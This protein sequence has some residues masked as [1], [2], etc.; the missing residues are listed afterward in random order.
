MSLPR[1]LV[2][3]AN[4]AIGGSCAARLGADGFSVL[5][6]TRNTA[7]VD[8]EIQVSGDGW[9]NGIDGKLA[10]V[11]WAQGANA[12]GSVLT[13]SDEDLTLMFDANVGFI[14]RTVR[15][16]V[17]ADAL[18]ANCRF[19]I[20]SSI[21]QDVARNEKF[22]YTVSKAAI[23]GLVRSLAIDLAPRGI[24]VNAVLPGILDTPMTRAN[25]SPGQIEDALRATP[26]GRLATVEDVANAVSWLS[27]ASCTAITAQFVTVDGGWTV[28]RRV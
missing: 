3:G 13:T 18:A 1:A 4:G 22:A 25:L 8:G 16:L 12:G 15:Q 7:R 5:R 11:I 28:H 26:A 27:G 10:A 17:E 14:A 9:A 23:A 21:W 19:V 24:A 6:A 20:V 2:F